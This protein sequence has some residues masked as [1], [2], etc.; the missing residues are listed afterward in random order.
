MVTD[1][2]LQIGRSNPPEGSGIDPL[3][4]VNRSKTFMLNQAAHRLLAD[5]QDLRGFRDGV[6]GSSFF[7]GYPRDIRLLSLSVLSTGGETDSVASYGEAI[8]V[9]KV[10]PRFSDTS[11]T[12]GLARP[13]ERS[14]GAGLTGLPRH[15][16]RPRR[17]TRLSLQQLA[18]VSNPLSH[19]RPS[20]DNSVHTRAALR[21]LMW[22]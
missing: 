16:Y 20:E 13:R 18:L 14:M 22:H 17:V 19:A 11:L 10:E 6:S 12:L 21:R 1:K 5:I 7:K 15:C 4:D 3:A 8:T 2:I 9:L